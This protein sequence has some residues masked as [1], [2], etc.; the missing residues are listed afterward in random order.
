MLISLAMVPVSALKVALTE[1]EDCYLHPEYLIAT[2]AYAR[3]Q[4]WQRRLRSMD[5]DQR[6]ADR[7]LLLS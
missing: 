4:Q 3:A 1:D 7:A 6:C 5:E 2:M